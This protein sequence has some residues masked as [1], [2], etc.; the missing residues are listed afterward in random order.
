MKLT[1]IALGVALAAGTV[2][3]QA[4]VLFFPNVA[5]SS[6]VTTLVS[7]ITPVVNGFDASGTPGGNRLHWVYVGKNSN[8][9]ASMNPDACSEVDYNLPHSVNDIQTVDLGGV[10]SNPD[11]RGVIFN[12][13]SNNNNWRAA[14]GGSY[15]TYAL[16][17]QYRNNAV[18]TRGYLLVEDASGPGKVNNL[19]GY[20]TIFDYGAGAAWGYVA[21]ELAA[22]A[23]TLATQNIQV[24]LLPWAE[25]VTRFFVTPYA[26]PGMRPGEANFGTLLATVKL[27]AYPADPGK[28]VAFDRDENAVSGALPDGMRCIGSA[29]A[30]NL[31]SPGAVNVLP[32]G[33]WSNLVVNAVAPATSA[34]VYQLNFGGAGTGTSGTVNGRP[35]GTFNNGYEVTAK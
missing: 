13:P 29:D 28:A 27:E 23:P 8:G 3:A 18:V 31:L 9:G 21:K 15:L 30:G 34:V 7:V 20:A 26:N 25:M 10:I 16:A 24:E 33:G 6:Q 19:S 35:M 17:G 11:D 4:D 5:A 12:D 2:A 1:K 32:Y 14:L 22:D